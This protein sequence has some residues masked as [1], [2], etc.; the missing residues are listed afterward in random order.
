MPSTAHFK[1]CVVP[2]VLLREAGE[3]LPSTKRT[4]LQCSHT[5]YTIVRPDQARASAA[6]GTPRQRSQWS[7]QQ[8]GSRESVKC[9]VGEPRHSTPHQNSQRNAS[10][11]Y[12]HSP[13]G[14][15]LGACSTLLLSPAET[16]RSRERCSSPGNTEVL[17]GEGLA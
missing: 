15:Q 3:S 1:L 14:V 8:E 9:D 4:S 10:V 5:K 6:G 7:R 13:P 2:S 16:L 17:L 12:L 11:V